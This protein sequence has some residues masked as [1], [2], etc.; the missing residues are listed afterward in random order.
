MKLF[1]TIC[2]LGGLALPSL[3]LAASSSQALQVHVPFSFM[4][5]GEE[6]AP[7]DYR[8]QEAGNGLIFVQGSGKAVMALSVPCGLGKL[9]T[10]SSLQ[11][12]SNQQREYLVGVNVEGEPSRAIPVHFDEVRKVTFTSS[13]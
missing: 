11:F 7:G 1:R 4:L 2:T 5:A 12:T 13:R 10:P 3:A 9:G 6:F 8:I